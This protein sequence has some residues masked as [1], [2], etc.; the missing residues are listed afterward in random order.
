[1]HQGNPSEEPAGRE[2][3]E[4]TDKNVLDARGDPSA[5]EGGTALD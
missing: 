4:V 2:N 3:P 5:A 1:M